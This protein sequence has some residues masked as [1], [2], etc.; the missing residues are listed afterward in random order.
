MEESYRVGPK[1]FVLLDQSMASGAVSL[2]RVEI[3]PSFIV[4]TCAECLLCTRSSA[5]WG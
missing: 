3:A 2:L 1:A 5:G 4:Q